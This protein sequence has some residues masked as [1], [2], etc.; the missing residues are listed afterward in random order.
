[1]NRQAAKDA[2]KSLLV[3][4]GL[5][6]GCGHAGPTRELVGFLLG[7]C[8]RLWAWTFRVTLRMPSRSDADREPRVFAFWHGRQLALL[9]AQRRPGTRVMVSWSKDGALQSGV[10]RALGFR[11]IRG[12]SSRGG[13]AALKQIARGI[14][15][16]RSDAVFAVDGP[17]GPARRA[18][19]GAARAAALG[20]ARLVAVGSAVSRAFS[21]GRSWDDFQLPLP[22]ARVAIFVSDP[23]D[24]ELCARDPAVLDRA[25]RAAEVEATQMLQGKGLPALVAPT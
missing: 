7:L 16:E 3:R 14:V 25:L 18:K 19:P 6:A 12:S 4:R 24:P 20:A 17:R 13:A 11:V 2:K 23:L 10:M 22:F 8:V 21:L 1:M 15:A 9:G 5:V